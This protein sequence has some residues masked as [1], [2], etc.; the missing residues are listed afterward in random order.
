MPI[1]EYLCKPC[2]ET[3]E[4]FQDSPVQFIPCPNCGK[5]APRKPS[6]FS[7]RI[8]TE[9]LA[10]QLGTQLKRRPGS[11]RDLK[12]LMGDGEL[13]SK[14]EYFRHVKRDWDY[15]KGNGRQVVEEGIK[16][17]KE[18]LQNIEYVREVNTDILKGKNEEFLQGAATV[19]QKG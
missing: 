14:E 17:A 11:Y 3:Y 1:Y 18:R 13:I 15:D 19:P 6:N 4:E 10:T 12:D 7:S 5:A 2:G 8:F 9:K 16:V